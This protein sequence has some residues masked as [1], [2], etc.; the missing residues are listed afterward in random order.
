MGGRLTVSGTGAGIAVRGGD[1]N[2]GRGGWA[3]GREG[4][5]AEGREGGWAEGR[6]GGWVTD[7]SFVVGEVSEA[8]GFTLRYF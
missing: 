7:I 3:E 8:V 4:G 1:R 5:W 6:E 2:G